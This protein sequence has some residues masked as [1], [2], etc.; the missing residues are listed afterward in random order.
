LGKKQSQMSDLTGVV[1]VLFLVALGIGFFVHAAG[2]NS[3]T[4]TPSRS[5]AATSGPVGATGNAPSTSTSDSIPAVHAPT[6]SSPRTH[7]TTNPQSTSTSN[8]EQTTTTTAGPTVPATTAAAPPVS[9]SA[10]APGGQ[11]ACHPQG[12]ENEVLP[13]PNCTPGT[14]KP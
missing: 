13:D 7:S 3:N 9:N 4:V 2:A 6:T 12:S 1:G 5:P 11:G 10:G 8:V 14:T